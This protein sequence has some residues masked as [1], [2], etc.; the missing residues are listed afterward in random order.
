KLHNLI[1]ENAKLRAWLFENTSE[2]M[3]NTSGTSVTPHVD[4]P[5]LIAV[6]PHRKKL[7]A[8]ILS[9][10]APQPREFN[11][12]KHRNVIAH[13]MFKIDPSQTSRG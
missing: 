10:S 12:M 13:G 2:S 3:N 5:K 9:H 1:Y 6:T 7:H 8:S 11:V 4:K